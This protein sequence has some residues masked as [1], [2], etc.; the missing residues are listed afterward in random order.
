MKAIIFILSVMFIT[1]SNAQ[2]FDC[3]SKMTEYQE[4]F[5]AKK[6][7]E[8]YDTWTA[9]SKN[10]PKENEAVY[11]DGIEIIQYKIDNAASAEEKEK[12]VRDVLKLYDQYN[13]YFP[14]TTTDFEVNKA[15]TLVANKIDAK[16]EIF[17]L[18]DRGFTKAS[19]KVTSANAIFTYFSMY[20][21]KFNNGDKS[22]TSN[23]V[24]EKYTLVNSLLNQLQAAK[25][26][27][28]ESEQE[29]QNSDYKTAQTAINKLIKDLATCE[30][31]DAFYTKNYTD[32][33]ENEDWITSA[34]L[35]LSGKCS[36]KPIFNTLAEKLYAM[37]VT[38]QS[39]NFMA[40]AN[41]QQ[42]KF[43]EAIKFYNESA[44][45]QT[46]PIE[47]A[48][49][50]YTLATGLLAN[51]LP[52]SKEYLKKA[53]SSDPKMGKAYLFLAQLY[54]NSAND[55]GKTDFEKKAVYYLAIQTA[56]KA[57]VAEPRLKPTADKA[58]KDYEAKSLTADEIS[59]RKMNG[60]LVTIGCWINETITF[61]AK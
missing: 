37:K 39:A 47:K 25:P 49:I 12:L 31:L 42:R 28:N 11:T 48:K 61:P 32:N 52:K 1:D 4:L 45:L 46:N 38:A 2:K 50:Y 13:K 57:G 40:L 22:I 3:P 35:S 34:L 56:Q 7:A 60:K 18:L 6:I 58:T 26:D 27:S 30:N 23:L 9:V 59:K 15:M 36:A 5:K 55:C 51:D 10:C 53:L 29:K 21:E 17:T 43:P 54:S 41:L 33:Q 24:L 44:E 19:N 14:L 20:C 8:S 16:E